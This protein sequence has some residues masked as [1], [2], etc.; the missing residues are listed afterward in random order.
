VVAQTAAVTQVHLGSPQALAIAQK[1]AE[2][3]RV[4]GL[5]REV[6]KARRRIAFLREAV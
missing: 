6:E 4:S 3:D 1:H 2:W 5:W